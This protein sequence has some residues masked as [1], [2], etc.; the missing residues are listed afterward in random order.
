MNPYQYFLGLDGVPDLYELL[1]IPRFT[2]ELRLIHAA[3]LKRNSQLK[4]WDNS[5]FFREANALLDEV[6][7]AAAVL[8]DPVR[9]AAFDAS[10]REPRRTTNADTGPIPVPR[11]NSLPVPP[12]I[13]QAPKW[14]DWQ[15]PHC[16]AVITSD[17]SMVGETG[18]C[19]LCRSNVT[20]PSPA[21][22]RGD[23]LK[24]V[25]CRMVGK[26]TL[27]WTCPKCTAANRTRLSTLG[28]ETR[29]KSCSLKITLPSEFRALLAKH[30]DR[31]PDPTPRETPFRIRK[32][33]KAGFDLPD[34]ATVID[35]WKCR[36]ILLRRDLGL[37]DDAADA[38]LFTHVL[39][40]GLEHGGA[41][42]HFWDARI[43]D[44]S[45]HID[46]LR[47]CRIGEV[48]QLVRQPM[49]ENVWS[50]KVCRVDGNSLGSLPDYLQSY[51][52]TA[53]RMDRGYL[54]TA[55][56]RTISTAATTGNRAEYDLKDGELVGDV[57][58]AI[59]NQKRPR[60]NPSTLMLHIDVLQFDGPRPGLDRAL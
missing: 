52:G 42:E 8:E 35:S 19:P 60:F 16:V 30:D 56:L 44:V 31:T 13:P 25:S 2:N 24:S 3:L 49:P 28:R 1:G 5:R 45:L 46:T 59:A 53:G 34:D 54:F 37:P 43:E 55:L 33:R 22:D 11:N 39:N 38:E 10:I 21:P 48:L 6:I 15:C 7:A 9:K 41:W 47:Q 27:E 26:K 12:V 40:F 29:C 57:L 51:E 4:S 32:L 36:Q 50:V 23:S 17:E 58:S 18:L 14:F 20:I